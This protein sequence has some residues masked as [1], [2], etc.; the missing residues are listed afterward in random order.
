MNQ[1]G[2]TEQF[3]ILSPPSNLRDPK[4]SKSLKRFLNDS[5]GI[6]S[7]TDSQSPCS[8]SFLE[9][10]SDP[11]RTKEDPED[12]IIIHV[13]SFS[14][15][16]SPNHNFRGPRSSFCSVDIP[17]A[18]CPAARQQSV[19]GKR[20]TGGTSRECEYGGSCFTMSVN[21]IRGLSHVYNIKLHRYKYKIYIY[22][23]IIIY[24]FIYIGIGWYGVMWVNMG[25]NGKQPKIQKRKRDLTHSYT[26][27]LSPL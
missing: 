8:S 25:Q 2:A 26:F 12:P 1:H 24:F 21:Q 9:I 4:R 17:C 14:K 18:G 20:K 7:H 11:I 5:R 19:D 27:W 16:P 13:H 15:D 22:I 3:R 10:S 23:Y 6:P